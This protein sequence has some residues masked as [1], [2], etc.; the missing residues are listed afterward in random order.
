MSKQI[1][2]LFLR[3][4]ETEGNRENLYRS[5]GD[6]DLNDKGVKQAKEASKFLKQFKFKRV[7]TSPLLRAFSTANIV[8]PQDTKI[9]QTRGLLPWHLGVFSGMQRDKSEEALR[10]FIRNPGIE[11][12]RGESLLNFE[13]RSFVFFQHSLNEARNNLTL[14]VGHT[15][16]CTALN[17]FLEDEDTIEPEMG[18]SVQ[19]GGIGAIYWDGKQHSFEVIFGNEEPAKFGGS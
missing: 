5:W 18:D 2:G 14:F 7:L 19:P 9:E 15:S 11:V 6:F 12:P 8:T 13:N 4:G 16:N 10:L 3:H 17:N 1:V